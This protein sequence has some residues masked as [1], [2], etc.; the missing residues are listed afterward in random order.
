MTE[1][2]MICFEAMLQFYSLSS[3]K[4]VFFS[5]LTVSMHVGHYCNFILTHQLTVV[6]NCKTSVLPGFG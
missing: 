2:G 3:E 1:M 4:S 5:P 6:I